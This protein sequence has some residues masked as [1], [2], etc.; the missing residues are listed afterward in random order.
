MTWSVAKSPRVAEQCDVNI[1][2][3]TEENVMISGCFCLYRLMSATKKKL[4]EGSPLCT[5]S[6]G[7][8]IIRSLVKV[9]TPKTGRDRLNA[10]PVREKKSLRNRQWQVKYRRNETF[11]SPRRSGWNRNHIHVKVEGKSMRLPREDRRECVH[12][13]A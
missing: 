11:P 1:H 5:P 12:L 9:V 7:G 3:L 6:Y 10:Y 4:Q 2:S 13:P 8:M